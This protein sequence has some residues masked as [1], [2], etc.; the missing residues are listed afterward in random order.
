MTY[1]EGDPNEPLA[2]LN[3]LSAELGPVGTRSSGIISN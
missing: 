1:K 3:G 2:V